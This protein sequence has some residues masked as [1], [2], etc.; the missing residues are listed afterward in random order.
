[1]PD[2]RR[3]YPLWGGLTAAAAGT[4]AVLV[5]GLVVVLLAGMLGTPA[6]SDRRG[7]GRGTG[8]E[9][10]ERAAGAE[11][12]AR[13]ERERDLASRPNVVVV[14]MDDVSMDLV[15]TMA[16]LG[17]MADRGA[18]YDDAHVVNTLCCPSRAA[19]FTGQPPHLNGVLTNTSGGP[20]GAQGGWPAFRDSGGP[21]RSYNVALQDAGYRTGFVGKYLNEYEPGQPEGPASPVRTPPPAV[22][23]WSDFESF[24]GGAYDG[25]GYY[26]TL[27]RPDGTLGLEAEPVPSA[28]APARVK[29]RS[30]AGTVIADRAVSL[31]RSYERAGTPYLLHV[32]PY[33]AHARNADPVFPGEPVFPPA[34]RDRG[35]VR[36]PQGECGPRACGRLSVRDLPG[37]GDDPR[38]NRPVRLLGGAPVVAPG[39]RPDQVT[40]SRDQVLQRYRDRARM[41]QSVD[42]ML[43]RLLAVVGPDTY[44]VVTSD[45]GFHLGQHGLDGGKGTPYASDTR[46]PLVV[47]GPGVEPGRRVQATTNLDLAPTIERLAGLTPAR[48]RAGSSLLPSLLDR[49]AA[50]GR[51]SFVEHRQGPV[52]PGEPDADAGSGGRLDAIPSYTAVRGERGLLVRVDL[53]RDWLEEQWAWELYPAGTRYERT[54]TYARMHD[55]PWVRDLRRRAL[56]WA[57]CSPQ[58]CRRLTR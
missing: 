44:V 29:D 17:R 25:W 26:R 14:V 16:R 57:D 6:G 43:G 9:P 24:S 31:A 58:E 36:S 49:R 2:P 10:A 1:M 45:N 41:V 3:W 7:T 56:A 18:S 15:P 51:Y 48:W 4:A 38:D 13:A 11:R 33:A 35:G 12:P 47:V 20:F 32:A 27:S 54:N 21:R 30:Y 5:I 53:E 52:L 50:G 19:T 42:R 28:T 34:F 39:W 46:V 37:Y 8:G 40:L 55:L 22:P 23:G